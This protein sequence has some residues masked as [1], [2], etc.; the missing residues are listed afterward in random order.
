MY[1]TICALFLTVLLLS[2]STT[3]QAGPEMQGGTFEFALIG[4]MPYDARQE[5]EFANLM[6]EDKCS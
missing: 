6:R 4:D 5:M 3:S 1:Q 2:D